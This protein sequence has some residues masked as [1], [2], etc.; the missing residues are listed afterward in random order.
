MRPQPRRTGGHRVKPSPL[1]AFKTNRLTRRS[2]RHKAAV[3]EQAR[4][5]GTD[6]A[7]AL[8]P[9]PAERIGRAITTVLRE[10]NFRPGR[11]GQN[12]AR[13]D[14]D[15]ADNADN[16]LPGLVMIETAE[17][18]RLTRV[19][20]R[21]IRDLPTEQ[22]QR[23]PFEGTQSPRNQDPFPP[24]RACYAAPQAEQVISANHGAAPRREKT[25]Q[26]ENRDRRIQWENQ[27]EPPRPR[28]LERA[29]APTLAHR[30][31][32]PDQNHAL[33]LVERPGCVAARP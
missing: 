17:A 18:H 21:R 12:G 29:P 28:T 4:T 8:A 5:L 14:D 13:P 33:F 19:R 22:E 15:V 24:T 20:R 11:H 27:P 9:G 2:A 6:P 23:Q 26:H 16:S 1:R 31:H 30:L 7:H 25:A 10:D 32:A 3:N